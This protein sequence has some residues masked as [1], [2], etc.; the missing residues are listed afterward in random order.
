LLQESARLAGNSHFRSAKVRQNNPDPNPIL[1]SGSSAET[2]AQARFKCDGLLA[3]PEFRI[4][5][6]IKFRINQEARIAARMRGSAEPSDIPHR[7]LADG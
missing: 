4:K 6:R 2:L 1:P 5:F 3:A 7:T